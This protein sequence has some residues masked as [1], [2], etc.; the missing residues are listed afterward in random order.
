MKDKIIDD[1]IKT[2]QYKGFNIT[3]EDEEYI[4]DLS[5]LGIMTPS[6][7]IL[8][9]LQSIEYEFSITE[10]LSLIRDEYCS[11][12]KSLAKFITVARQLLAQ[13]IA[14]NEINELELLLAETEEKLFKFSQ[15]GAGIIFCVENPFWGKYGYFSSYLDAFE[16][17]N[18]L[19][20]EF[21]D[22][23]ISKYY[24]YEEGYYYNYEEDNEYISI[25]YFN[26][27]GEI[28]NIDF[29]LFDFNRPII[30][31]PFK[32]GDIVTLDGL[33]PLMLMD[34][35]N[36]YELNDF[37]SISKDTSHPKVAVLNL[38]SYRLEFFRGEL[39]CM[40]KE[41]Y[42]NCLETIQNYSSDSTE[43]KSLLSVW[44]T[45]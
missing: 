42:Q 20:F 14:C 39:T 11:S 32:K 18:K 37:L 13:E 31:L 16:M 33:N 24:D 40:Q 23:A 9:Y 5:N 27:N 45:D 3:I 4:F 8:K 26:A 34:S 43:V 19:C 17:V 21:D 15:G 25:A 38:G 35:P 30:P 44:T 7:D 1:F 22:I 12:H 28:T 41:I 29:E 6:D 10:K 36:Y 2:L